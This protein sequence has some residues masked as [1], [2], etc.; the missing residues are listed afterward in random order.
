MLENS[1]LS[2][3]ITEIPIG[4]PANTVTLRTINNTNGI[5]I[6]EVKSNAG[7]AYTCKLST[8]QG[9]FTSNPFAVNDRVF[10]E[11]IEKISGVGS[12]FNSKDYGYNLL[13]VTGFDPN[14]NGFAEVTIDV[15]EYGTTNTGIAKTILTSFANVINQQDYPQFFVTQNQI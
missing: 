7:T 2:T 13:K 12:G 8:P 15:S 14:V 10:I 11:G 1:I 4:L 9:Q 3:N 6:L 5:T